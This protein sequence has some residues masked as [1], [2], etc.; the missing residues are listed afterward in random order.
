MSVFLADFIAELIGQ[1]IISLMEIICCPDDN[2]KK[3]DKR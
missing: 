1:V 3:R 2:R